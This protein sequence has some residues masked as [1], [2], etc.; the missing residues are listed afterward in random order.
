MATTTNFG[1]ET[2]DD[3][4]LVK[5]GASAIRTLGSS[6]DTT[7]ATMTP[8]TLVDAKGDLLAATAADTLARLAVGSNGQV[9]TADSAES[10]GLKWATAGAAATSYTALNGAGT[11]LTGAS[12]ITITGLSGY[13]KLMIYVWG[14]SDNSGGGGLYCRFNS[15]TGANYGYYGARFD[16]ESTYAANQFIGV[17]GPGADN[18]LFG[19]MAA[20]ASAATF[21]FLQ[22]DGANSTGRKVINYVAAGN[23]PSSSGQRSH[24]MG[25]SYDG[26]SV[27]SSFTIFADSGNFDA[28]TVRIFGAN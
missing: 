16:W 11:S 13:N 18:L 5:D 23:A 8:K 1:W 28:G 12:T 10:T 3:T 6:I 19:K 2:P 26:T 9:L 21:G 7:M 27:I 20:T 15:D 17:G 22:I 4:D 14:A 24:I 25:A